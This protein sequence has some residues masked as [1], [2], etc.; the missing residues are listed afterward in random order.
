MIDDD[1]FVLHVS[2]AAAPNHLIT[3]SF[4]KGLETGDLQGAGKRTWYRGIVVKNQ[5]HLML[6][7][8][9]SLQY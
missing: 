4:A 8:I 1:F 2:C 9:L 6:T 3:F 5:I 7:Y